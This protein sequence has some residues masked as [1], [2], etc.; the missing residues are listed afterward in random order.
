MPELVSNLYLIFILVI[1]NENSASAQSEPF[2]QI[3]SHLIIV[4]V[5][6]ITLSVY[7]IHSNL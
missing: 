7:F 6:H 3:H 1:A 2:S 4:Q 5:T